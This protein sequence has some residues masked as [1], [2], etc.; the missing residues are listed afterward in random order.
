MSFAQAVALAVTIDARAM[1]RL[2]AI[3]KV[4]LEL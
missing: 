2:G 3:N 4:P 1:T